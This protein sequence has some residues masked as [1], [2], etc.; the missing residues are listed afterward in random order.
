MEHTG[1]ADPRPWG[2]STAL[3][4]MTDVGVPK[5]TDKTSFA[6]PLVAPVFSSVR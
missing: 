1:K 5:F 6:E 4:S 2:N 3:T